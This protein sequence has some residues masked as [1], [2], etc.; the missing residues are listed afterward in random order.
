MFTIFFPFRRSIRLAAEHL[1][2]RIRDGVPTEEA[3]NQTSIELAQCAEAHARVFIVKTFAKSIKQL[4]SK[5]EEFRQVMFQLCELYIVY[6]ALKNVG[7]FLRVSINFFR[8]SH[9]GQR[10]KKNLLLYL[11]G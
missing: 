4:N 3:W 11:V 1:D 10:K 9:R 5:S 2:R 6:W 8:N 7:N